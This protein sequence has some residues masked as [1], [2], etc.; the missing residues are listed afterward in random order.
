MAYL[1]DFF[2]CG[3]FIKSCAKA[4]KVLIQLLYQTITSLGFTINWNKVVDPT[5]QITFRGIEIDSKT[6]ELTLPSEKLYALKHDLLV[7]SSRK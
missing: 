7:F 2:I 4:L 3:H 6:M 1:D 5:T